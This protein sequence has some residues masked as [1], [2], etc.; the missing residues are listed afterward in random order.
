MHSTGHREAQFENGA[1][2]CISHVSDIVQILP[3]T[4]R[5]EESI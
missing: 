4:M 2:R 5:E 1:D 3:Q